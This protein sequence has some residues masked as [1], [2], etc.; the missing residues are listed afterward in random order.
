MKIAVPFK[1]KTVQA[2]QTIQSEP[3]YVA[4]ANGMFSL[5]GSLQSAT[6]DHSV[7]FTWYRSDGT[8]TES[9][10]AGTIISNVIGESVNVSFTPD[11]MSHIVIKA[12]NAVGKEE[13]SINT[14]L[15]I[16][17]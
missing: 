15:Y 5:E 17:A 14:L 12:S 2:G 16:G 10:P 6:P 9:V 11:Y 13:V 4:N 7:S 1:D 3:I 8:V